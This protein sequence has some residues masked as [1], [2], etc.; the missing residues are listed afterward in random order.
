MTYEPYLPWTCDLCQASGE[1]SAPA[2]ADCTDLSAAVEEA[3]AIA[4][5]GC[6]GTWRNPGLHVGRIVVPSRSTPRRSLPWQ[7]APH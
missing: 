5:P 2:T 3:H 1:V 6:S 7:E 4:S